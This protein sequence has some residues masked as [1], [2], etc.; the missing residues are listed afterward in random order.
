MLSAIIRA[1]EVSSDASPYQNADILPLPPARRTWSKKVFAFFWLSTAINI[2]EWSGASAGLAIGL[3]VGQ[4]IA[5]NLISTLIITLALVI[6][7][8]GGGK[9]HVPFAVINRSA[10]GLRGSWFALL[11]RIILSCCWYGVEGWYGGQMVKIMIGTIWPSFYHMKNT[12]GPGAAMKTNEFI[13]FIIFW[14]ISLPIF[15]VKPE[16]YRIPAIVSSVIVTIAA[17]AIFIWA[18]AKQ[19]NAGPLWS[20]PQEI[21]GVPKLE[22]SKLSWAMMR[23]ITSGIG[24]WAGGILYQSDFSRYAVNPG[25]QMWGQIFIIPVCLFGSNLLG[26]ITTSCARGLFPEE[27]LLWRLYD[28]LQ[29][30]QEHGGNGTR[31]AVFFAAFA[32]FLSQIC[33]NVVACGV[34]GGMD[35]AALLPRFLNIRRGSFIIAIIG[36]CI[37]PWRI[38]NTANSFISAI[39]AYAVFLGPLTGI[40][41]TDYHILRSRRLKLSHLYLPNPSSDYWFWHG[42]NWRAPIAWV[43]GVFPSMPG[44]AASVTPASVQVNAGWTHVYYMSWLLSFFISGSAWMVLN[45]VWPP[46]GVGE[47]DEKDVFGTFGPAAGDSVDAK[48]KDLEMTVDDTY[49]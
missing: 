42:L 46:P 38:L 24:G 12:F 45:T 49:P 7:G 33:V 16:H 35:L 37:N 10:W 20:E 17:L 23:I 5:V 43:L 3:T 4:A 29:A 48:E 25:D 1:I 18:L 31:A 2:A 9:W 6:N 13:S 41:V 19:G 44:F 47:V 28:L 39:S 32:F 30:I 8:H 14:T 15:L 36:I 40:M 26:L 34:V 22:G 21:Y 11:N 27:P